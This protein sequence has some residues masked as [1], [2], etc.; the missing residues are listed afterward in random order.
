MFSFYIVKSTWELCS[1]GFCCFLLP[2]R[3]DTQRT[4]IRVKPSTLNSRTFEVKYLHTPSRCWQ[5]R[6]RYG[7][8]HCDDFYAPNAV[9]IFHW[10]PQA[11]VN[12]ASVKNIRM[13]TEVVVKTLLHLNREECCLPTNPSDT[14]QSQSYNSWSENFKYKTQTYV[15]PLTFPSR[16]LDHRV[17]TL[18][19]RL[20]YFYV[21]R[22]AN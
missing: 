18:R 6:F 14:W 11:V 16:P 4:K 12:L 9:R 19:L 2:N 10:F 8:L 21:W 20:G 7:C 5:A 1:F 22:L 17:T 15:T 13:F 3:N